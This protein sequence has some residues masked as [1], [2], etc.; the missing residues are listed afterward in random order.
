MYACPRCTVAR[1]RTISLSLSLSLSLCILGISSAKADEDSAPLII[2][3]Y[4][5]YGDLQNFLESHRSQ[6]A[7]SL[8][9]KGRSVSTHMNTVNIKT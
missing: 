4:M 7:A 2:L 9:N 5:Q 3:E 8:W 1:N 6:P